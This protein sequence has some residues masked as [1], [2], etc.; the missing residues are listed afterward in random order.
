MSKLKFQISKISIYIVIILEKSEDFAVFQGF[1]TEK[2]FTYSIYQ[3][4]NTKLKTKI[5]RKI[6]VE[7]TFL[8]VFGFALWK[9]P[10][11]GEIGVHL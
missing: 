11:L 9:Y 5:L 1:K 3:W 8:R 7:N 6:N 4:N 2:F 10:N